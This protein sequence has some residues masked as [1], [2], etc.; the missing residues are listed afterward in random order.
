[1]GGRQ[2]DGPAG[3]LPQRVVPGGGGVR[4]AELHQDLHRLQLRQQRQILR[5][6]APAGLAR[7][8]GGQAGRPA[9]LRGH[10][11]RGRGGRGAAGVAGQGGQLA[12]RVPQVLG[13]RRG[14]RPHAEPG[15]G[16]RGGGARGAAERPA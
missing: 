14:A 12:Q 1:D 15:P 5:G 10:G 8:R 13:H 7:G 11:G 9:R 6:G 4:P 2:R 16:V 3:L